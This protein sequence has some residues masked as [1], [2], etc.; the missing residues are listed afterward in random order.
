MDLVQFT[1]GLI[2][3]LIGIAILVS[4]ELATIIAVVIL[5]LGAVTIYD[6]TKKMH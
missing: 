6:A 1:I 5:I 2:M 4:P 3:M